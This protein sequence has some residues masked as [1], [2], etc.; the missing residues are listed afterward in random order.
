MQHMLERILPFESIAFEKEIRMHY[1]IQPDI[2]FFGVREQ[3]QELL[4]ILMDNAQNHTEPGG[5]MN[6]ILQK[7]SHHIHLRVSNTGEPIAEEERTKL[8]ERFYRIDKARNRTE[9]RYGL[10]LAI[11]K[12][13]VE[14][15]HGKIAVQC[16]AGTTTFTASFPIKK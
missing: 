6:I 7:T 9:G 14:N 16:E 3:L 8:F 12:T 4:V 11:A 10:G 15:H 1:D 2:E 5:N 13:I